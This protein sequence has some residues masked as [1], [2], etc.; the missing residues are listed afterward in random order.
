IVD[1]IKYARAFKNRVLVIS[2]FGPWFEAHTDLSPVDK[3]LAEAISESLYGNRKKIVD[4][5][6]RMGVDV[7]D[8]G[9][10]DILPTAISSYLK[11]KRRGAGLT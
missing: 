1:A 10:D 8:V 9:P 4:Q 2:P 3:A 11:A 6:R 5:I 7:I